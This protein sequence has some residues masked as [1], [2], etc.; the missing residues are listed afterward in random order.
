MPT[1]LIPPHY[2]R[3]DGAFEKRGEWLVCH[4]R[5]EKSDGETL[6]EFCQRCRS[7]PRKSVKEDF[8][9]EWGR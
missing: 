5:V 3:G 9:C 1:I 2:L 7:M 8:R 4:D 6:D